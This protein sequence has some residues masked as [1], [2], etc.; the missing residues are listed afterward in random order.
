MRA[1][2][3]SHGEVASTVPTVH[4]DPDGHLRVEMMAAPT[5]EVARD[6]A[7]LLIANLQHSHEIVVLETAS[8][9]PTL[10]DRR[11]ARAWATEM[12]GHFERLAFVAVVG[13]HG[14]LLRMGL[15]TMSLVN[16][17]SM[18]FFATVDEAKQSIAARRG[19]G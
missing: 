16:G 5:P 12:Q 11:A 6:M 19:E 14:G 9:Q 18:G 10:L 13:A 4:R 7:R 8:E 2:S 17:V 15:S 3:S 1:D